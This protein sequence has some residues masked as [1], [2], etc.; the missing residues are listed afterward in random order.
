MKQAPPRGHAE[1]PGLLDVQVV[2]VEKV[3]TV[4]GATDV[5]PGVLR[6]GPEDQQAEEAD[7]EAALQ[8]G[9]VE[10]LLGVQQPVALEVSQRP[11]LLPA[12]PQ[13]PEEPDHRVHLHW[14]HRALKGQSRR[15]LDFFL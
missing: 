13:L 4:G 15:F 14:Q 8:G 7:G 5:E 6:A 11:G 12:V 1:H 2:G 10:D 3:P 9:A